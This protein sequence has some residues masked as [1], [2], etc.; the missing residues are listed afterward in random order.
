MSL[1][2]EI[3]DLPTSTAVGRRSAIV[4]LLDRV[5]ED[6]PEG[7]PALVAL[8]DG[9]R[10]HSASVVASFLADRLDCQVSTSTITNWRQGDLNRHGH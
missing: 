6:D 4:T 3:D 1:A 7:Y 9:E 2:D 8:I 5:H 10:G